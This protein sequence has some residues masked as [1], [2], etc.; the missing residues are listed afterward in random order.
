MSDSHS[1]CPYE[2]PFSSN[3]YG[4][5][6]PL[7]DHNAFD[8]VTKKTDSS[9]EIE[10]MSCSTLLI[11]I[12]SHLTYIDEACPKQKK[13]GDDCKLC[14][15]DRQRLTSEILEKH[16][17]IR[18]PRLLLQDITELLNPCKCEPGSAEELLNNTLQLKL[19]D[20]N[21]LTTATVYD[22]GGVLRVM[23]GILDTGD[24]DEEQ[25]LKIAGSS[26]S[27]DVISNKSLYFY[28]IKKVS[29]KLGYAFSREETAAASEVLAEILA[30]SE[31]LCAEIADCKYGYKADI[32]VLKLVYIYTKVF[33]YRKTLGKYYRDVWKFLDALHFELGPY[34]HH[35]GPIGQLRTF[36]Q[37]LEFRNEGYGPIIRLVSLQ[38]NE[39]LELVNETSSTQSLETE[40]ILETSVKQSASSSS[41]DVSD[42]TSESSNRIMNNSST[43][44]SASAG[45]NFGVWNASASFGNSNNTATDQSERSVSKRVSEITKKIAEEK[46]IKQLS[47][48]KAATTFSETSLERRS[49]NNSTIDHATY[50]LRQ[51]LRKIEVKMWQGSPR[52][53]WNLYLSDPARHM[54]DSKYLEYVQSAELFQ[55][56]IDRVDVP[57]P[58][59]GKTRITNRISLKNNEAITHFFMPPEKQKAVGVN[60]MSFRQLGSRRSGKR[61]R[62]NY[63]SVLDG[64]IVIKPDKEPTDGNYTVRA[65]VKAGS[66]HEVEVSF[67]VHWEPGPK[68]IAG[69]E[70][71]EAAYDASKM[72]QAERAA[73]ELAVEILEASSRIKQRPEADLRSEERFAVMQRFVGHVYGDYYN[74]APPGEIEFLQRIFDIDGIFV[75]V[76]PAWWKTDSG[77]KPDYNINENTEPAP[78]GSSLG[79]K[80]QLDGDSN[81]NY[82]INSP[83]VQVCVPINTSYIKEALAWIVENVEGH[84]VSGDLEAVKQ[85]DLVHEI[86]KKLRK[87]EEEFIT[88]VNRGKK[89]EPDSGTSNL[90]QDSRTILEQISMYSG[91]LNQK[92]GTIYESEYI[93][94]DE[95]IKYKIEF[96][97][98]HTFE[99]TETVEGLGYQKINLTSDKNQCN[100]EKSPEDAPKPDEKG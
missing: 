69:W 58:K 11:N 86:D 85:E 61:G 67:D 46:Q 63:E 44:I 38:P 66:I 9:V 10:W 88:H 87:L 23:T 6:F 91:A 51:I 77:D 13:E 53:A 65:P 24:L 21:S 95:N 7:L 33:K 96:V 1:I 78:L 47:R 5:Y 68:L 37:T 34:L 45:G 57:T 28:L 71:K 59:G 30:E 19:G 98:F 39:L 27:L 15:L 36:K 82:F 89:P 22:R 3:I 12:L 75:F 54:K 40:E 18:W 50:A 73:H 79:W 76:H 48:V 16:V 42:I 84:V 93:K 90:L 31:K 92:T 81:R 26:I 2:G 64:P 17:S 74:A 49:V 43:A 25:L 55:Q 4:M 80:I 35:T 60:N 29:D 20:K 70:G 94:V 52:F 62:S 83:W 100:K 99:V 97:P 14:V 41:R 8:E 56:I 72:L 32:H